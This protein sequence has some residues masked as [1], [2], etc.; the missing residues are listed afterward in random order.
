[1]PR[2]HALA[3]PLAL[4]AALLSGALAMAAIADADTQEV[5]FFIGRWATA[6]S[7]QPGFET[8]APPPD[9]GRAVEIVTDGG[10]LITRTATLRSGERRSTRFTVKALGGTF[11]WWPESGAPA[12]VARRLDADSF[13]LARTFSG[14]ADW[15]Q[16]IKHTRCR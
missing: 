16:A 1:M 15:D 7:D 14:K 3:I 9:C 5:A 13:I 11:P 2:H 6:P 10:S 8:L 4:A 12:L